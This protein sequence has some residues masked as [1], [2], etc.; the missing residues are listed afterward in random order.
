MKIKDGDSIETEELTG[1][2]DKNTQNLINELKKNEETLKHVRDEGKRAERAEKD[3]YE[4]MKEN[5]SDIEQMLILAKNEVE[6][7][8]SAIC[9]VCKTEFE[10]KDKL[11]KKINPAICREA[12]AL[13]ELRNTLE[14]EKR[15]ANEKEY[16]KRVNDARSKIYDEIIKLN[17]F[18]CC[19]E[20]EINICNE[21][22]H[23]NQSAKQKVKQ[24]KE[25]LQQD[26]IETF[27]IQLN[28]ITEEIIEKK[29]N[30][31]KI[32]LDRMLFENTGILEREKNSQ[33]KY[34]E[35][36]K[37]N[38]ELIENYKKRIE[39]FNSDKDN[40]KKLQMMEKRGINSIHDLQR[41]VSKYSNEIQNILNE[42]E[43]Q[44]E[45]LAE[46]GIY[47]TLHIEKYKLFI[48]IKTEYV[49][50]VDKYEQYKNKLFTNRQ[51]SE[52]NLKK[53][54]E[55]IDKNINYVQQKQN[56]FN[57]CIS[58]IIIE[59]FVDKYNNILS[60]EK[61]IQRKLQFSQYK[62]KNANK[63][64]KDVQR[65]LEEYIKNRFGSAI[66]NQ[67]YSKIEPHK[68]FT[69]LQYK[70]GFDKNGN[71][72]MY[73][74][75]LNETDSDLMPELFFSSAQLNTVALSIFLGGALS[76]SEPK[77]NTILI[78]DPIG[79]FDDINVLSFIDVLRTIINK[80]NWQII[81][82]THE[83]NFYEIMKVKLSS[84]YYNSKFFVFESEGRIIQDK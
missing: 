44:K 33:T 12:I 8:K 67:I 41:I 3:E 29:C 48:E 9:P 35:I 11:L 7:S 53:Y 13:F 57:E 76:I 10:N 64:L 66:I 60:Q 38:K 36:L 82:S 79:H 15:K 71:P 83:E 27:D 24:K 20:D 28:N 14:K 65:Q 70:L 62:E 2:E 75:A 23:D 49:D 17:R 5:F 31:R 72:E 52:K 84:E 19:I 25:I 68:R 46:Y 34:E 18:C 4:K 45:L 30:E 26:I 74:I 6:K 43:K 1:L 37:T 40:Q 80:T 16:E 73:R 47:K 63:I 69:R 39:E 58:D 81:I 21:I 78:D 51:L 77:L 61:N 32:V 50:W 42:T 56:I 54:K 59:K 55:K 22:L